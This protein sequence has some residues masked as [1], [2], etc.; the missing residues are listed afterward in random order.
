MTDVTA[1]ETFGR[2]ERGDGGR[3]VRQT[4]RFREWVTADGSSGFPAEAGRY[5]L[6]VSLACP[7]AHRAVIVR[8][9][10]GLEEAI[11]MSVVDPIRDRAGWAFRPVPG[12]TG[13]RLHGW[14]HLSEAYTASDPGFEGR[15]TV[16]VL[17]DTVRGRIVTNE[18][19]DLI[20]MLD[21][22]F[23]AV[24]DHPEV[25]LHPEDLREEI[26]EINAFVYERVNDG[27]YRAGFA[28]TQAAY[29]EAVL[30]LFEALDTLDDR[31]A[32]R[33]YLTGDRHTL[34][35][36]R[37]FTTLL[38][39]DPVYHGHFKC[40]LRR[41]ADYPNLAPY[42]RD[43]FQTPGVAGTVDMDHIKRHYYATHRGINPTGIVPVGPELDLSRPHGRDALLVA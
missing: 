24:A 18:S 26:A 36:W 22:A 5:H 28:S 13:D 37:L 4:S 15:I 43:L 2:G 27:V 1:E 39:F 30:P 9:L 38:R 12:A 6:Y 19:A 35:D 10:K 20:V 31:L 7:W 29:E 33:R 11:P 14:R 41:I 32:A 23:D 17:W 34:A 40:N 8:R 3:F 25:D 16:P 42:L 21:D